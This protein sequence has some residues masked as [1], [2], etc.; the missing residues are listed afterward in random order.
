M[1]APYPNLFKKEEKKNS[2]M[3]LIRVVIIQIL[4]FNTSNSTA[5]IKHMQ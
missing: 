4:I 3:I 1:K 5:S 2:R